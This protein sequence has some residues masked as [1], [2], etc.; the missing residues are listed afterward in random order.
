M[1]RIPTLIGAAV[2][3]AATASAIAVSAGGAAPGDRTLTF[4]EKTIPSADIFADVP[5]LSRTAISKGDGY[6]FTNALLDATGA[7]RLGVHQA[8]CTYLR[9]TKQVVGS[10]FI[11]DGAWVLSDGMITGET[12]FTFTSQPRIDFVVTG[13]T[14]AYA[15]ARGSGTLAY[16]SGANN[17]FADTV[18]HLL[19]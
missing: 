13:G 15:G 14:G 1:R 2:V 4:V 17:P 11:C 19:P 6:L 3:A 16:R 8:R 12:V 10:R 9:A 7:Q 5:P 18:I